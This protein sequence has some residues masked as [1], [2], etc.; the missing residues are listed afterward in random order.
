MQNSNKIKKNKLLKLCEIKLN[1]QLNWKFQS[2]ASTDDHVF[3]SLH[4]KHD[5]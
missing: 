2:S 5:K 3:V 1:K 4:M